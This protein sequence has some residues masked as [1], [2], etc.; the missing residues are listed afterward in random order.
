MS[1]FRFFLDRPLFVR[2]S[3]IGLVLL[4]V[5]SIRKMQRDSFP[6]VDL[7]TM[8][9]TTKYLGASPRDVEENVTRL[10]EDELKGVTG[11]KTFTSTSQEN[12]SAVVV[13]IDIDY[14]DQEEVKDEI[15]RAVERVTDLPPEVEERPQIRDLK[16]T[17]FPVLS[18]GIS[19]SNIDYGILREVAKQVEKDLK[20]ISGVS[21]VDKY[22]Y[23]DKEFLVYTDP[24]K[25]KANYISIT[26][27]LQAISARNIRATSG[28][29]EAG[30]SQRN[31]LTIAEYNSLEDIRETIVRSEFGGGTIRVKNVAEV[32]DGFEDEL[33]RTY[34][35]GKQGITL[36]VKKASTEDLIRLVD[37]VKEYVERKRSRIPE[38][39]ELTIVSDSSRVVRNR[40]DIVLSN[41]FFGFFLVVGVMIFFIDLR[42][43]ILI[44]ASIPF[45]FLITTII[46]DQTGQ[47]INAVS[48]VAMITALG[49]IV[50]QSVVVTENSLYYAS[51][52]GSKLDGILKGTMEVVPPVF[53]SVCTTVFAF[54]P[55]FAVTG[56]MGKFIKVIPIVVIA[57][58]VGSLLYSW[59]FLPSL[60]NEFGKAHP[61][62]EDNFRNRIDKR[63][64]FYYKSALKTV[65]A[66]RYISLVVLFLF[67]IF[68]FRVIAP[69]VP[70]NLFPSAGADTFT[71]KV[72]LPD[73]YN[74]DASQKVIRDIDSIVLSLS[75]EE[76]F[77]STGK[78]GTSEANRLAVPVG[79]E[80][81]LAVMEVGLSP[82]SK[83]KRS[84]DEIADEVRTRILDLNLPIVELDVQVAKP[85]PPV[86]K[87]IEL[88]VHSDKEDLRQLYTAKVVEYLEK[89]PGVFDVA[90]N[91]KL[92][93][94]EYKLD[95]NFALLGQLGLTV[96]DVATTLRIA[97]DGIVATSIVRENEEIGIR[98]KFPE[99][100]RE[101]TKNILDLEVR[102]KGGALVPIKSFASISTTRADSKIYHTDGEVTTT[103]TANANPKIVPKK[104][105][106]E[107]LA[108]FREEIREI[109]ELTI[110]YGGEAEKSQE[111]F[112][113][114]VIAF[115]LGFIAIYL[116]IVLLFE[117]YSQPILVLLAVPFGL[118]GVFWAFFSHGLPFSFLAAIGVIGLSGIVVNNSIMM[119]EFINKFFPKGSRIRRT[120]IGSLKDNARI[121]YGSIRRLRPIVITTG[122]TVLGLLPTGY[123]IGGSDPFL[124][125]MVLALAYGI[126]SSTLITLFGIPVLYMVNRDILWF[127]VRIRKFVF[128]DR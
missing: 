2:I 122:T 87:P 20:K 64:S 51:R 101:T 12:V 62:H 113:S 104:V 7:G 50:D 88:R 8:I 23:R 124:E 25:L 34:F 70:L 18:V 65:L 109:A 56:T 117:S 24:A 28:N 46:M 95:L 123:G 38:G 54:L 22:A 114:L 39:V 61:S 97:F 27:V 80:R 47:S 19:G 15:R 59:F 13:E 91:A 36:T 58:L 55:M 72:E 77:Y 76:L 112:Q 115:L 5:L 11:I 102:N 29:L 121:I 120:R 107:T 93:R 30:L 127:F 33:L 26:D 6:Q 110:S 44:A 49:M 75:E 82:V 43:S 99:R 84:A 53:A 40:I 73:Y 14:P 119:V 32:R 89:Y 52:G 118:T 96:Q 41:A 103:I 100:Y 85:G 63:L 21:Q 83:R 78:L 108:H 116:A 3:L 68:T 111:S 16:A 60:V 126:V 67:L 4:S 81:H 48:L 128:A 10:I 17:E 69:L 57:S 74:F 1:I 86:G 106:D 35:N 105:V 79:G 9:I 94:E 92:G 98:V 125:P 42:S 66:K 71:I 37:R 31:I 90:T 45:S